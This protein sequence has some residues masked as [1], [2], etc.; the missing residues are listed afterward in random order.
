MKRRV[1]NAREGKWTSY[2]AT[3]VDEY[4]EDCSD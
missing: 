2:V 1:Y 3:E 4:G